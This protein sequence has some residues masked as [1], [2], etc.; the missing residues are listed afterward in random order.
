MKKREV[1]RSSL[2]EAHSFRCWEE[3]SAFILELK[4]SVLDWQHHILQTR[5]E[6]ARKLYN[7]AL[8]YVLKQ[9]QLMK[10]SKTFRKQLRL[11]RETKLKLEYTTHKESLR[12]NK[13][14]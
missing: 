12:L 2:Q 1:H 7:T 13:E 5:F 8:S 10:E 6:L 9:Y 14:K 3:W 4:L 11:Y